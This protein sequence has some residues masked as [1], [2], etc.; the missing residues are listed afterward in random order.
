MNEIGLADCQKVISLSQM[1]GDKSKFNRSNT[2][3][4]VTYSMPQATR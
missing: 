1:I 3:V 4:C 2:Q